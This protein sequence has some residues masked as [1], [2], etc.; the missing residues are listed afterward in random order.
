MVVIVAVKEDHRHADSFGRHRPGQDDVSPCCA[1]S[2]GQ[3]AGEE[4]AHAETAVGVHG[5]DDYLLTNPTI[6]NAKAI[7]RS[8]TRQR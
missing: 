5:E 6:R 3:G 7:V 4:E 8:T 2:I 1:G